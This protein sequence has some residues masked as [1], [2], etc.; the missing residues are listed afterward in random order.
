[1]LDKIT[2]VLNLRFADLDNWSWQADQG[3]Y[4]EP[5]PQLIG[6]YRIMMD[7]DILHAI[8]LHYVAMNWCGHLKLL[9]S[10]LAQD[11]KFWRVSEEKTDEERG[12]R[13]FFT[14]GF[15]AAVLGT[16][17]K[18]GHIFH[19]SIL[20]SSMPASLTDGGDPYGEDG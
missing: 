5:R 19:S 2:D 11:I 8:F 18:K 14:D 3:M 17:T 15:P 6:E 7:M 1:V 10:E 13:F 12:R 4:Y 9:L 20:M 16:G